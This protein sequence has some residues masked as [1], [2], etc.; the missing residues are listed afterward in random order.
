M[1]RSADRLTATI[2]E[3]QF[4]FRHFS[5]AYQIFP[6]VTSNQVP[7]HHISL[8]SIVSNTAVASTAHRQPKLQPALHRYQP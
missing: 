5:E 2:E 3:A 6:A 1:G 8:S 7:H 4:G